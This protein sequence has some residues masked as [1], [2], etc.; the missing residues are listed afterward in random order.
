LVTKK[1]QA[2]STDQVVLLGG[3]MWLYGR[4]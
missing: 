4:L 1:P 3:V 2:V